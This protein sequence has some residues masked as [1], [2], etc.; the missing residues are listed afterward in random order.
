MNQP[1]HKFG[2]PIRPP[3]LW[4]MAAKPFSRSYDCPPTMKTPLAQPFRRAFIST[5]L[6][7]P[8]LWVHAQAPANSSPASVHDEAVVLSPFEVTA[9]ADKSYGA[10]NSNSLTAFSTELRRMPV[11]ADVF[12]EAFMNDVGLN[13]VE[14]MIQMFSAGAGMASISPDGSAPNSQYLDRNANGSLSLRGLAAP[15]M[16]VNGFFPTGGGGVTATGIT[17]NFDTERVEVI[18]GPQALLYGVSGAGGV[19]NL[20]TKQARFERPSFGSVKF[21]VDQYGHKLGQIDY[22]WGGK[23]LAVR[24]TLLDQTLG[25]RRIAI[26]GPVKGGYAQ[27]AYRLLSN[28]VVRLSVE[29]TNMDRTNA[30]SGAMAFTAL[31]TAND[32]RNGQTM[33]WLLAT[34]QVAA[35]ANGGASGAGPIMNGGLNW[36]NIDTIGGMFSGELQRHTLIT[37]VAETR[38]M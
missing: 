6:L 10:L 32:A 19:V 29:R 24:L 33:H 37:A 26:G 34:G 22:G 16:Q 7:L 5:G 13:T 21:Q 8:A 20:V 2:L 11:S 36:D 17:S 25:G 4:L 35:A 38:W 9:E 28:T 14:Q 3:L 23:R 27:L 15:T 12:G 30:N 1:R 31:S 18:S